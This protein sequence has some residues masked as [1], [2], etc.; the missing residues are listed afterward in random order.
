V[1]V[2]PKSS[3]EKIAL[4]NG[5]WKVWVHAPPVDQAAN[6]AVCKLLANALHVSPSAI[7]VIRGHTSREKTL[8]IPSLSTE[9]LS[10]KLNSLVEPE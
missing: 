2:T 8:S 7:S 4:V 6:E 10:Q 3:S 9:E 1:R 5:A